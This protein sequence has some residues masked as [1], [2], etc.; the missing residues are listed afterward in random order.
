MAEPKYVR[1][2][3][4]STNNLPEKTAPVAEDVIPIGDSEADW[5]PKKVAV[6]NLPGGGGGV[7][8]SHW[9]SEEDD[10]TSETTSTAYQ[11]KLTLTTPSDLPAGTYLVLWYAEVK[12]SD[13]RGLVA[14]ACHKDDSD[15]LG[16]I[17]HSPATDPVDEETPFGGH[18]VRGMSGEHTIQLK[19]AV[20]NGI[21]TASIR[22]AHLALFRVA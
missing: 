17:D 2:D 22:K 5:M 1:T 20:S 10:G 12:I 4:P 13:K 9:Q 7:F 18:A 8:G 21:G 3:A 6:G 15:Y 19:W 16:A 14:V 11:V